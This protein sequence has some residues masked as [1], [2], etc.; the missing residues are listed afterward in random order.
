MQSQLWLTPA[1]SKSKGPLQPCQAFE[2]QPD[3]TGGRPNTKGIVRTREGDT[4]HICR[5]GGERPVTAEDGF[6]SS[7]V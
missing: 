4:G 1:G 7:R 3:W 2:P 6:S 5:S